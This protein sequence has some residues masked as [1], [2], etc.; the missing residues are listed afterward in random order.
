MLRDVAHFQDAEYSFMLHANPFPADIIHTGPYQ[1]GKAADDANTYRV[2]HPLA[3]RVLDRGVALPTP[4]AQVSFDYGN[5]GRNIAIL[6]SMRGKQGWLACTRMTLSALEIEDVLMLCGFSDED[7]SLH[8]DQCRRMFD[9]PATVIAPCEQPLSIEARLTGQ[10]K[11]LW[12]E[13][14]DAMSARNG[15]W[16]DTEM[17]KLDAWADDRRAVLKA[18]LEELDE[19]LKL[20]RKATRQAPTLPEKLERQRAF[21]LLETKR[22]EAW[23]VYDQAS[24]ELDEQKETLLDEISKRLEQQVN[25]EPL[26]A[27]RW[28]LN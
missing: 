20:A 21:R 14:L 19:A 8:E 2:G 16:F 12:Q 10:I 22:D 1:M 18:E 5:S 6:H 25:E 26:F 27:I 7:A 15:Q 13:K 11:A 4:P 9:L 24:R 3:L 28:Q 23:R 17:D